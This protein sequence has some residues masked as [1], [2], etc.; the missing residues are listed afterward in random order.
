MKYFTDNAAI[1]SFSNQ[2]SSL[3]DPSSSD[4][5]KRKKTEATKNDRKFTYS[6]YVFR[7]SAAERR[8]ASDVRTKPTKK[9]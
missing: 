3:L 2:P 7:T 5:V 1:S 8:R 6:M 4:M 9:V